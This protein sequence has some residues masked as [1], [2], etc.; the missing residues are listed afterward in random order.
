M[1]TSKRKSLILSKDNPGPG[2]YTKKIFQR[3]AKYSFPRTVRYKKKVIDSVVK[4]GP[5]YYNLEYVNL[6]EKDKSSLRRGF[7]TGQR[8]Q[9]NQH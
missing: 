4:P 1:K 2:R 9:V 3:S 7:G 5:G 8:V 6:Y